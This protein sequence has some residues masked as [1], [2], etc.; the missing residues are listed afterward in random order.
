MDVSAPCHAA[1]TENT[2]LA[3]AAENAL[4]AAAAAGDALVVDVENACLAVRGC[5]SF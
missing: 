2:I 5:A 3:A 4:L 1:A